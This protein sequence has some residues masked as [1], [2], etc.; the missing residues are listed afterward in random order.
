M[1]DVIL[2]GSKANMIAQVKGMGG[3][4]HNPVHDVGGEDVLGDTMFWRSNGPP[5]SDPNAPKPG[6]AVSIATMRGPYRTVDAV[7]DVNGEIITPA[8]FTTENYYY[9][10]MESEEDWDTLL[11]GTVGATNVLPGT[12]NA[13]LLYATGLT[14]DPGIGNGDGTW[15]TISNGIQLEWARHGSE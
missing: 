15:G 14:V 12:G 11:A 8:E 2:T 5:H 10:R 6:S 7:L 4:A 13:R 9:W 1:I 3:I